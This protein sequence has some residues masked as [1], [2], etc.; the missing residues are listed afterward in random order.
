M[1]HCHLRQGPVLEPTPVNLQITVGVS[2]PSRVRQDLFG[3]PARV[4]EVRR[5]RVVPS[6]LHAG[7]PELVQQ[8]QCLSEQERAEV[9]TREARLMSRRRLLGPPTALGAHVSG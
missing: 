2:A 6:T 7:K 3:Q 5:S 1:S 4:H 9:F 8:C